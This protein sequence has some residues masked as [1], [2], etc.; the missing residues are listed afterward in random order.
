MAGL[1][2]QGVNIVFGQGL[3]LKTD[4]NQ[5][6][7]GKMLALSNVVFDNSRGENSNV[8]ALRKRY[9]FPLLTTLPVTSN[10]NITTFKNGLIS[11]GSSLYS[12]NQGTDTWSNRGIVQP[13]DIAVQPLVRNSLAQSQGNS[14]IAS[15]G[16]ICT[17]YVE[18]TLSY[19][20]VTQNGQIVI[21]PTLLPTGAIR[22]RVN[23]LN[24]NF[25]ITYVVLGSTSLFCLL[26]PMST[27][28]SAGSTFTLTN[29]YSGKYD[30]TV[31]M[32]NLYFA[33]LDSVT[34]FVRVN[35]MNPAG[36][37]LTARSTGIA[38]TEITITADESGNVP[39][40]WVAQWVSGT[41]KI[42]SSAWSQI[43]ASTPILVATDTVTIADVI[44]L[45]S[46]ATGNVLTL[47]YGSTTT[48]SYN[49]AVTPLTSKITVTIAGVISASSVIRRSVFPVAKPFFLSNGTSYFFALY[50]EN[51]LSI[52]PTAFLLSTSGSILAR[53]APTNAADFGAIPA[54]IPVIADTVYFT[55]GVKDFV[56]SINQAQGGVQA[57]GGLFTLAGVNLA[58]ITI[59]ASLQYSSE[60]ASS[61]H[62]TGGQLWQYDGTT[63][64]E[65]GFHV[66]PEKIGTAKANSTGTIA[67]GTYYYVACYEWTDNNGLLHRSAPS[68]PVVMVLAGA[69]DTITVSVPTLRLTAKSGVRIVCYR[70]SLAQ[71]VYYMVSSITAPTANNTA[72]DFVDFIDL[73]PDASILGNTLLYTTGGVIENI[74][75]PASS[76]STLFR[77]RLFLTSAENRNLIW[78]SKQI[79][80]QTPV[81]MSDLFTIFVPPTSGAQGSTGDITALSSL[82]DKLIIFKK[83][84]IYYITGT[85][86]DNTGANNDFS[87]AVYITG[88]VGCDNP[89]S[90]V[91][92]PQGLMFQ[93]DK[94]I[95]LLG[96][97]LQTT[98]IGAPVEAYNGATVL[99][100]LTIPASTEVRFTL[101]N[102]T[103]LM[104]DYFYQQWGV[105]SGVPG[106]S[107]TLYGGA[108]TYLNSYGQALQESALSYLDNSTPV[109]ISFTTAWLKLTELQGFQRAYFFYLLGSYLSPHKLNISLAYDYDPAIKQSITYTP[110]N[111]SSTYGSETLY[112]GGTY[113]GDS[114][115]EQFRVFFAKQKC[116]AI[117][118]TVQEAF[119]AS[120]GEAPGAGLTLS[121]IN[122]VVG[123]KKGY[124]VLPA[125]K[126]VG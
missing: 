16:L 43:L 113:G 80:E 85:G 82:D 71:P 102:G 15:N 74:A 4:A 95:W 119:D 28:S 14:A 36:A 44:T 89:K 12:F 88:A 99:S 35:R 8:G 56:T 37:L 77:S 126:S 22:P 75:A 9:G 114:S 24:N 105:F 69:E 41:T 115:V 92:M 104:Y 121:G 108:H 55:Y 1:E 125:S 78:Y 20:Q 97:D 79:I 52:Q 109:T 27:P 116:Q 112:G 68:L 17:V 117:Q 10:T 31:S 59:N 67:N 38:G 32:G 90:I 47:I 40:I 7:A 21:A 48:Y 58:T 70:W 101:S 103:V 23:M 64:V 63:P 26:I 19:Y 94:G 25:A 61:L 93:S 53:I 45:T 33:W 96:R 42:W 30:C 11:T 100:G 124:P 46:I 60:I 84:S 6:V 118:I 66:F 81:E 5:V 34:G 72:V 3:D 122:I 2:K 76:A 98:Y 83:S 123:A 73:L 50:S 29:T 54:T 106:I 57:P 107:S 49:S 120:K 51:A 62:L 13:V 91:Q 110:P 111:V 39:V 87:E 65:H 86:P 18:A